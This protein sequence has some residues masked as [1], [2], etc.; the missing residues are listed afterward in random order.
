MISGDVVVVALLSCV[1]T[2][3]SLTAWPE[4]IILI[5]AYLNY[6]V[7]VTDM[8]IPGSRRSPELTG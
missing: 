2:L 3:P 6:T 4:G 7:H 5:S 1:A 8:Q